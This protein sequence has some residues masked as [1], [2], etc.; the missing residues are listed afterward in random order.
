MTGDLDGL[1]TSS[2]WWGTVC[3]GGLGLAF[4]VAP[5]LGYERAMAQTNGTKSTALYMYQVPRL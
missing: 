5:L 1:Y 3:K 2:Q 4:E